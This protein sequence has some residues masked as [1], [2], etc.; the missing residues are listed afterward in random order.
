[1]WLQLGGL[2]LTEETPPS[3]SICCSLLEKH[4]VLSPVTEHCSVPLN[5]FRA[6]RVHGFQEST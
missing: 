6:K 3:L 2:F 1:M 4:P 5:A